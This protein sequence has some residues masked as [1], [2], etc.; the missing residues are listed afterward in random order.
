M[1]LLPNCEERNRLLD[2]YNKAVLNAAYAVSR[3]SDLAGTREPI[4]YG[5]LIE[6]TEHA[7]MRSE[8]ARRAY[9]K[10]ITEHR[11]NL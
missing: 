1:A 7:K 6:E 9:E 5:A 8:S 3:L 2:D 10:H 4:A 11:C